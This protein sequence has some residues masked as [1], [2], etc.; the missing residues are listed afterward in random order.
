MK[1]FPTLASLLLCAA[2]P[3]LAHASA[4]QSRLFATKGKPHE[5]PE[6]HV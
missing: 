6:C 1:L 4:G 2:L 3:M 5:T